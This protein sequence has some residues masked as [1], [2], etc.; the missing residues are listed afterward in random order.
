MSRIP[1]PEILD[2]LT[3]LV[4]KSLVVYEEDEEG[5]GRYRLLETVRKYARD[6]LVE[7]GEGERWRDRHLAHF[8]ALGEKA[9]EHLNGAQQQK[10]LARLEVE[11]DNLRAALGWAAAQSS[12]TPAGVGTRVQGS[13]FAARTGSTP[14]SELRTQ[15]AP[16]PDA[17]LRL[18]GDIWRFWEVRGHFAEGRSRMAALLNLAA[19]A[20]VALAAALNGA[21]VLAYRQGDYAAARALCEESLRIRR[22][23]QD[24]RG[25]AGS[26]N[27]LGNAAQEQGDYAAAR[28]LREESLEIFRELG[29]RQGTAASLSNLG[30]VA[31]QQG[32]YAAA[33]RLQEESLEIFSG[34]GERHRIAA[35][36]SNLGNLARDRGDDNAARALHEE[37]LATFSELGDRWGIA[38]ALNNLGNVACEQG[39]YA[40]AN[41][42]LAESLAIRSELSERRGIAESLEG[43]A[44][45]EA[46]RRRVPRSAS[47]WAAAERLREE[48]GAPLP[49]NERTRYERQVPAARA[50]LGDDA[51]FDT[52]WQEGRAMPL[53]QA[54]AYALDEADA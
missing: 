18:A 10:W 47:L 7:S 8:A 29:D 2:P 23:L 14:N 49:P 53:E 35:L 19:P 26:L 46:A 6:R 4:E 13:E 51:A 22:E 21:G 15:N 28:A 5:R 43:L 12:E 41:A 20:P 32:D 54:I 9:K 30:I 16:G 37:S 33:R 39:D 42:V 3:R 34:L 52:A 45:V 50:V 44:A 38:A 40:A 11:H 25:I 27:N 24:R 1:E 36:L 31:K 17:G 48:I